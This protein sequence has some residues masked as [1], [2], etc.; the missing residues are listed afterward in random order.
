MT[1]LSA[2]L[3]P[4]PRLTR[5]RW[6]DLNGPW[7]F[8]YDDD[9]VGLD[10]RWQDHPERFN[11]TIVVPFPP[12]SQASGIGDTGF[13]PVVWYRRTFEAHHGDG[14]TLLHFGAVDYR[15]QVWVNGDLVATHE[16]GNTPFSTD[17]TAS[18]G[19]A[20]ENVVVVRA[21]D[22][23]GD[24]TQARGKQDWQRDPHVI[25]YNR[26]TGIW[27]AVWLEPVPATYIDELQF[28]AD[29]VGNSVTVEATLN[30]PVTGALEFVLT[31]RGKPLATQRVNIDGTT[32]A[33]TI[34]I[35]LAH[36]GVSRDE[37]LWTPE[38]PNLIE[39]SVVL[40]GV[41][42]AKADV[43]QSYFGFR[44]VAVGNGHFL[45]NDKPYFMRSVLEQ[46]YWPQSHLAAPS[47]D[48]LR[49]EVELIKSLGFNAARIHQKVEDPRF[50][51]WADHLGLMVWGEMANAYAYSS[52]AAERFAREWLSVV[53][54]DRSHPCVVTWVPLNESWGV[55][56]IAQRPEQRA[57][58]TSLYHLT[59]AIDPTR[60]VI[61]NDGWEHTISDIWGVHDY[62]QFKEQLVDRYG[63]AEA[64]EQTLR[65]MR[66][67]RRRL[68]LEPEHRKDQPVM[69]TEFGGLS[70]LPK[71][72]EAWFGYATVG[73][74]NEYAETMRSLFDAIYESPLLAGFCYTQLTDTLQ[75]TNGLLD[76][77][78]RAK[79]PI[80][81]LY[82]I[83][84]RPSSSVPSEFL[85]LARERAKKVS[86]G[87]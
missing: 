74:E 83:I 68:L 22:Q 84:S 87:V 80:D 60:P 37:L 51:Y 76:E 3:H 39:V 58:A 31:L 50:L 53:R 71:L 8:A 4:R 14:R 18:L 86:Q 42:G 46:G 43:V 44:S 13:H 47:P 66:A 15:A 28:T 70:Y 38:R 63:T 82:G 6:V 21:E 7:G 41:D 52:V 9:D 17:I 64:V 5:D 67:G 1:Q 65:G 72:G 57:F 16:G 35:P 45:L 73:D 77:N 49:T 19:T 25:W 12:E 23:P 59:K 27:Q 24:V 33:T 29:I 55:P 40:L 78:R 69:L 48:A 81:V 75:E 54:R 20:L 85:D 62:T 10:G 26:T 30:R 11:R 36:N 34:G 61:S 56:A 79:L 32:L 2:S